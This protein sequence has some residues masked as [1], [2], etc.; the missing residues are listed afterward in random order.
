VVLKSEDAGETWTAFDMTAYL[1]V[2]WACVDLAVDPDNNATL[3]AIGSESFSNAKAIASFDG[4]T[5]WSDVTAGLPT[6]KPFNDVII[7]D[8]TVYLSGGQLFGG[9]YMGIYKSEDYGTTW[10]EFSDD[11]PNK[12]VNDV[13]IHPENPLKIYAATEGDGVYFTFNGGLTWIFET[14]GTGDNGTARKLIFNPDD[15]TNVFAGYLSLGV[16]MSENSGNEWTQSSVGIASLKL[17]DI[18]IDPNNPDLVFAS[19]E[20]ENSGGCYLHDPNTLKWGLVN[21]L[22]GTRFSAV[23]IGIDGTIYAWSNGPTTVAAEGVYKSTDGGINWENMGPNIGSV[24]E[25]Q[26][27]AMATS[28]IDANLIFIAGNNFGA[29]GWASMIYRSDD[30]GENWDN[31]FMG[32]DNDGF[33][34]I[35]IDPTSNDQVVYAAYKSETAGAGFIKSIDGGTSWL[36]INDGIPTQTKWASAIICD[37]DNP[38]VLFGGAGGYGGTSGFVYKSENGGS[39][40]SPLN[41]V[42][43]NYSKI[44]DLL[45]SPLNPDVMYAATSQDGVYITEDGE[46]WEASNEGL[47]ATNVTGFSRLFQGEDDNYYFYGSTFTN[48]AYSTELYEPGAIGINEKNKSSSTFQIYPN[49]SDGLV[50]IDFTNLSESDY[51]IQIYNTC[52]SLIWESNNSNKN[53]NNYRLNLEAGIYFVTVQS[54]KQVISEKIVVR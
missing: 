40:W 11:F 6:G 24:F 22:P 37:P 51:K 26:I 28:E 3:F 49:P 5:T 50:H 47:P 23:S 54:G 53:A 33:K 48:S 39:S 30:G 36:P 34:Y 8:G 9:N 29:N 32:P 7:N 10:T 4:G 42:T 15:L 44:T 46:N 20:A 41:I 27:F 31:V 25:T 35:Y 21:G 45:L 38:D 12:V 19:F 13:L 17:N 14:L 52:G 2:G 43:S 18:E 1:P 16:C